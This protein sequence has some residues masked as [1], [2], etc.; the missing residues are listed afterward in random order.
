M[1]DFFNNY[2][3]YFFIETHNL[4]TIYTY[5]NILTYIV[6]LLFKKII[7]KL[8]LQCTYTGWMNEW[9]LCSGANGW[10]DDPAVFYSLSVHFRR[11]LLR[12][13][14]HTLSYKYVQIWSVK[15]LHFELII[16]TSA[17]YIII[18]IISGLNV[19][20]CT[21]NW[22]TVYV[23]TNHLVLAFKFQ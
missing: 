3:I 9:M 6:G 13:V 8:Q 7:N 21:Y 22:N 11:G 12:P 18:Q 1:R 4:G 14:N 5:R 2:T 19:F 20:F 10:R 15:A 16:F 17:H 23:K